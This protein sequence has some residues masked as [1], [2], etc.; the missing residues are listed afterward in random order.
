MSETDVVLIGGETIRVV[1]DV[2]EVVASITRGLDPE[3]SG[4]AMLMLANQSGGVVRVRVAAIGYVREAPDV[5]TA[6]ANLRVVS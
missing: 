6:E 5:V 2:D 1:G 3:R 4:W